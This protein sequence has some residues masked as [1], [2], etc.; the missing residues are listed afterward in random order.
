M[1]KR[2]H[3]AI[4]GASMAASGAASSTLLKSPPR[5]TAAPRLKRPRT[6]HD[7]LMIAKAT[8]KRERKGRKLVRDAVRNAEGVRWQ[9]RM[10]AARAEAKRISA[11]VKAE[12]LAVYHELEA[13]RAA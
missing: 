6:A 11:A 9:K 10:I 4:L 12:A 1:F 8:A 3:S 5:G 7:F 2:T 13:E